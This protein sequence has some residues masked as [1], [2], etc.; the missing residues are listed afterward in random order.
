MKTGVGSRLIMP[1]VIAAMLLASLAQMPAY[2]ELVGWLWGRP[3][4]ERGLIAAD[5]SRNFL[6]QDGRVLWRRQLSQQN[7]APRVSA[8]A[9]S[10]RWAHEAGRKIPANARV[11]LKFL[12]NSCATGA[13]HPC[14]G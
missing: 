10:W 2:I 5:D 11:S 12:L 3:L 14:N 4:S 8:V 6:G 1:C 7:E 9:A 13:A